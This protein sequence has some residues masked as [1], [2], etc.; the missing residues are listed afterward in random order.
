MVASTLTGE[1]GRRAVPGG[2][3]RRIGLGGGRIGRATRTGLGAGPASRSAS[4]LADGA[5][6]FW[7]IRA[8]RPTSWRRKAFRR[9]VELFRP[10]L[11]PIRQPRHSGRVVRPRGR[12][13][14]ESTRTATSSPAGCSC[15]RCSRPT[16]SAGS[17]CATAS[18]SSP[19]G[20]S[21]AR[22]A[23]RPRPARIVGDRRLP[24]G[25]SGRW[26]G[27]SRAGRRLSSTVAGRRPRASSASAAVA[28]AVGA[29]ASASRRGDHGW[30]ARRRRLPAASGS[31]GR[32]RSRRRS[33]R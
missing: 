21:P 12:H 32:A 16:S 19:G 20:R 5:A 15:R 1:R 8:E 25:A 24:S 28:S 18:R 10:H 22:P 6:I 9:W 4:A 14:V 13:P 30:V 7:E 27:P 26:L 11:A 33:A 2:V 3:P 23:R 29:A 17:S 31:T